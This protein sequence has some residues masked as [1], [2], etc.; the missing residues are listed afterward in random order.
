MVNREEL[1]NYCNTYLDIYKFKDYCPN[2]LQIEGSLNITKIVSGVSANLELIERAIEEKADAI[3]VHHGVFWDNELKTI[4]GA[5]R[6]KIALL[7]KHNINLFGFH[8]PLDDHYEVGNNVELGRRLGI[9]NMEPVAGSL[10]WQGELNTNI[11][12]F[13]KL[14]EEKLDRAPQV[15]GKQSGKIK[16]ISWCTGAAQGF[17][18]D[19]INLNV[20]LYL[21]GEVSEKTPAVAKENNITFISAGHHAT[22]RYG[23]QALCKHLCSQFKLQH[24]YIEVDNSV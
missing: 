24:H 15:F 4:S 9:K 13:S 8:L 23:V 14:I 22:E 10:L 1:K 7:L 12:D 2:G 16:K 18:E 3:F 5:K 20:D 6:A 19:A 21:S 17:I 11:S